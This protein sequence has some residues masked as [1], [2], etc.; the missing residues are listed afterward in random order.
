MHPIP[1]AEIDPDALIRDRIALDP[2]ALATLRASIASEGLR[3]PIE[4]W[5]LSTPRPPFRYGLISGLRRLTAFAD[6]A[7]RDPAFA[8]IPA[9]LRT[10]ETIPQAMA[11]MV[12][13]NEIR[14][15][16][17]PWEKGR[18]LCACVDEGHFDT[19]DAAVAALYPALTRQ[20]RARLRAYATVVE[21]LEGSLATPERLSITRMERLAAALRGG[22]EELIHHTLAPLR[23][24]GLETQWSALIPVLTEALTTPLAEP[25]TP[26]TPTRPRRMLHLRQGLTIRREWS[27]TGWILRFSGPESKMGGLVDDVLDEVERLFQKG[28]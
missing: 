20:A 16:I 4:V 27:R 18:L 2:E 28:S 14:A 10:P 24:E 5:Q 21:A 8:T 6:L 22:I 25:D 3:I 1:L 12:T 7:R 23:R 9:V 11:A 17:T 13:E 26:D 15:Q 19:L